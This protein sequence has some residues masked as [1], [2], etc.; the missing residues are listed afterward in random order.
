M[1]PVR[2]FGH[3]VVIEQ[4]YHHLI[5]EIEEQF[6]PLKIAD[7]E[8]RPFA[9]APTDMPHT[10][11]CAKAPPVHNDPVRVKVIGA[12]SGTV[13]V[14]CKEHDDAPVQGESWSGQEQFHT[15]KDEYCISDQVIKDAHEHNP[16]VD[17]VRI[18]DD[19]QVVKCKDQQPH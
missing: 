13:P 14:K 10:F 15:H 11:T 6:V 9:F 18:S 5:A 12:G 3:W 19:D 1:F 2:E 7:L 16:G 8:K 4:V 17:A